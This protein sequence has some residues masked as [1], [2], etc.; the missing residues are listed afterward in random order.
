MTEHYLLCIKLKV[1]NNARL[2]NKQLCL[3]YRIQ[4]KFSRYILW[5]GSASVMSHWA[6][7]PLTHITSPDEPLNRWNI[8]LSCMFF[9]VLTSTEGH[10]STEPLKYNLYC[11]LFFKFHT[12]ISFL[13]LSYTYTSYIFLILW[14]LVMASKPPSYFF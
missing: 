3:N 8:Y 12:L 7:K 6:I 10:W 5:G 14:T 1:N 9:K 2:I 13:C 4:G 11:Y